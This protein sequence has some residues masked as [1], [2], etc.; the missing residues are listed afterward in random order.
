MARRPKLPSPTLA[1][2]RFTLPNG[3]RVVLG[4]DRSAPTV[5][6]A[7]HYDVGFRSEPEGRTGF[8]HLFEHLTFQGSPN[9]EKGE[10]DRLI[11]GNGGMGNGSTRSDYTN[12]I[13]MLPS[14]AL[15]L[16]L[17]L[18]SDRMRGVRLTPETLQNQIDVVK[19]EIRVNVLN[20]PYGGFPWIDLPPVMFESFNN[21]HDGYGS[22]VDLDAAT[23]EAAEDFYGRYYAPGNA[24]LSVTGDFAVD[25]ITEWIERYFGDLAR[26]P[27]LPVPDCA[28]PLP[29]AER[30]A[31]KEDPL[32]P[33]PAIAVGYRVPDPID[34]LDEYL[35]AVVLLEVLVEGEASRLFR[36]MVKRDRVVT[37]IGGML[38]TFGDPFD[39]RDPVMLQL[40]GYH[41]GAE[42]DQVLA[43]IDDEVAELANGVGADELDRVKT[44]MVS[45][46]VRRLDNLLSRATTMAA[47]EQQRGRAELVNE[48]PALLAAVDAEAVIAAAERWLRPDQRAVLEVRP[49]ASA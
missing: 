30:R 1:I 23:I 43:A 21:S 2:A 35:A 20:R 25:E 36:R 44:G 34:Q 37:H 47:L 10:A 42:A 24:V 11:E 48:L 3:L 8:A 9:L 26:R 15:E 12:Y 17:F 31:V 38:G 6:L 41:P 45:A 7:V 18:E 19:E 39:A 16:G 32:A 27:V 28:E 46:H 14:N 22:F 40:V 4:P 29:T 13:A 5:A 33:L 49:G